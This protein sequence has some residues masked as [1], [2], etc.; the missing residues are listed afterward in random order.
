MMVILPP[1]E[2]GGR[3]TGAA[4]QGQQGK[5]K[6]IVAGREGGHARQRKRREKDGKDSFLLVFFVCLGVVGVGLHRRI[7]ATVFVACL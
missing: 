2:A 1:A 7:C 3:V 5:G 4:Y 6:A